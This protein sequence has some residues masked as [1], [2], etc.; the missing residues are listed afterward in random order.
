L[1]VSLAET[2]GPDD[3]R[4][5]EPLMVIATQPDDTE[6]MHVYARLAAEAPW[7]QIRIDPLLIRIWGTTTLPAFPA[8]I[9]DL[10]TLLSEPGFQSDDGNIEEIL[11]VRA[12]AD[13]WCNRPDVLHLLD[14][15]GE[16]LGHPAWPFAWR[17]QEDKI[18]EQVDA[19]F[20]RLQRAGD[21]PAARVAFDLLLCCAGGSLQSDEPYPERVAKTVETVLASAMQPPP[22]SLAAHEPALLR[23][24]A[25]VVWNLGGGRE[26]PRNRLWLTWCLYQW[27]IRQIEALP[28]EQQRGHVRMLASAW[29]DMHLPE[30]P[31]LLDPSRFGPGRLDHRLLA[32]LHV[33]GGLKP[34][35]VEAIVTPV[36]EEILEALRQ[37]KPPC[38]HSLPSCSS[39]CAG[40]SPPGDQDKSMSSI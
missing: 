31:D 1:A 8:T 4:V 6:A 20:A 37:R 23:T 39:S 28:E 15:T 19:A 35:A 33:L 2:E 7:R 32:I 27:L 17:V 40:P 25:R 22:D 16:I 18:T 14:R 9:D 34:E 29:P 30:E 24:A 11:R 10:R 13:V 5:V 12:T 36:V 3:G 21:Q 38:L 26:T